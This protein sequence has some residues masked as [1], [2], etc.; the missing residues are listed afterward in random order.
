MHETLPRARV[1][2]QVV[3]D[4]RNIYDRDVNVTAVRQHIGMVFQRPTPFPTMSIRDNVAAGLSTLPR[5][6]VTRPRGRDRRES[7]PPR[8]LVGRGQGSAAR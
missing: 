8:R 6:A 5:T 2:G 3:L 1:T 4:G 7:T